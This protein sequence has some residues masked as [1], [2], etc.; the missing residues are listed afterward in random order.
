MM[1]TAVRSLGVAVLVLLA[2]GGCASDAE[3]PPVQPPST[4]MHFKATTAG[5]FPVDVYFATWGKGFVIYSPGA[6]P[7]Y[8]VPDS[9]GGYII[10]TPN[11][12]AR[13]VVARPDGSGWNVLSPS[14]PA[15]F[16]LKQDDGGYLLQ[17][18][19]EL[20]TLIQPVRPD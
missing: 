7:L 5:E 1:T 16:L 9:Q 15:T 13:W 8:L 17:P 3:F 20:P 10:Q 2:L 11:E 18:P 14:A 6:A 12:G 19:G 4:A